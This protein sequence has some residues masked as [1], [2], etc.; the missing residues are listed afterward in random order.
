[1]HRKA[2]HCRVPALALLRRCRTAGKDAGASA[3]E[4]VIVTPL[5]LVLLL[6]IVQ[7]AL[8]EHA[9]HIAQT[10]AARALAA[11]RAQDSNAAA[12]RAQAA[13]TLTAIGHGVLLAPTVTVQRSA[14]TAKAV[15]RGRVEALIPGLQLDVSAHAAGA[16]DRWTPAGRQG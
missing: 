11:A 12:G 13:R 16:V 4:T 10:A 9:Q 6:L 15:V 5:L 7:F 2:A 8:V 1:M 14:R 3:T